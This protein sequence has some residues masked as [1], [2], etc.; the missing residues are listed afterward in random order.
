[1][2]KSGFFKAGLLFLLTILPLAAHASSAALE[3]PKG[4]DMED[5]LVVA[6]GTLFGLLVLYIVAQMRLARLTLREIQN[7]VRIKQGLEP[8]PAPL[9]LEQLYHKYFT[10][11]K[12]MDDEVNQPLAADH[13]YDGI[14]ELDNGM[15]PWLQYF[16]G[17]TIAF[18]VVY[19][20]WFTVLGIGP[21]QFEEYRREMAIG[22]SIKQEFRMRMANTM[23]ENTVTLATEVAE[24]DNGKALYLENC[25]VCHG[26][27]GE[28]GVGPNLTDPYWL[29]GGGIKNVFRVITYGVPDKGMIPWD[30]RFTPGEIRNIASYVLSLD[31]TN[32]PNP[33]AP[34]GPLWV[35]EEVESD[36]SDA[37]DADTAE[38]EEEPG[39][40]AMNH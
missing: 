38:N 5:V 29:H 8:L 40:V 33:K 35:P 16:F 32:P 22:D 17:V 30:D 6:L 3:E 26:D 25:S 24:L 2:K 1:M 37:E 11:L 12:P 39:E 15:P 23:D 34:E 36:G 4:A 28:G 13:E 19:F 20:A 14:T 7:Q 27:K 31:G 9:S 10:G 21:D 18:A